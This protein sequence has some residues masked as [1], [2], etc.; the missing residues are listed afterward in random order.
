MP[1]YRLPCTNTPWYCVVIAITTPL[2][3]HA[4]SFS[5]FCYLRWSTNRPSR[6]LHTLHAQFFGKTVVQHIVCFS[7]ACVHQACKQSSHIHTVQRWEIPWILSKAP[8]H[9]A[10]WMVSY[11]ITSYERFC[12]PSY[13][14]SR[15]PS[16]VM[17]GFVPSYEWFRTT[18]LYM[19][20][21]IIVYMVLYV[22]T[23]YTWFCIL[24]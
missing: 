13:E 12:I 20:L 15:I 17:N 4:D 19:I 18:F 6:P 1:L 23:H 11:T 9:C 7:P 16:L 2:S 3:T 8:Y 10:V 24:L 14:W 5:F 22:I 21:Y